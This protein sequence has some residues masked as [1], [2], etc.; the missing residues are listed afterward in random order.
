VGGSDH[1]WF[2]AFRKAI[3][4]H[5]MTEFHEIIGEAEIDE[6]YFGTKRVRGFRGKLMRGRNTQ[7]QPVFGI[8]KTQWSGIY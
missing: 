4:V 6:S 3:Y 5:Q 7:I 1:H 8:L 2:M